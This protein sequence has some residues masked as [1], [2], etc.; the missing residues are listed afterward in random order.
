M[1]PAWFSHS[2]VSTALCNL[3]S[4]IRLNT[5]PGMERSVIPLQ[6]LQFA[7]SPFLGIFTITP[8]FQSSGTCL[9][10]H[11]RLKIFNIL[12]LITSFPCFSNYVLMQLIPG[13]LLLF[14]LLMA[15]CI[16]P[17]VMA[18]MSISKA[19]SGT[20]SSQLN[21]S[22][23][24]GWFNASSKLV[25]SLLKLLLHFFPIEDLLLSHHSPLIRS[26]VQ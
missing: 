1:K 5:F 8:F 3:F 13:A 11:T 9:V 6:F 17:T 26:T 19:S 7:R 22:N 24:G 4:M 23:G 21:S 20:I 2:L 16:S 25:S 15:A 10:I 14:R 18:L 12:V